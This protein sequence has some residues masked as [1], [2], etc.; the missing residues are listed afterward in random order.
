MTHL[1]A[2]Y[3]EKYAKDKNKNQKPCVF[4]KIV[5][6]PKDDIKNKVL[7]RAKDFFI[8]M[9][10]YP[11]SPGHTMVIPNFHTDSIEY[12][13]VDVW[14]NINK[15]TQKMLQITKN[16]LDAKGINIGMN[17]GEVAGAGISKH[18]H[19]HIVPR[20]AND[21][22]FITT[23]ADTRVYSIDFDNVYTKLK[24]AVQGIFD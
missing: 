3:R 10:K 14:I 13:D 9:N 4:C 21:S 18:I 19:L 6:S 20:W 12:L 5:N 15:A 23:I 16:I 17:L 2:P 11:Y 24:N 7:Y 8:V 22:N 1:Y